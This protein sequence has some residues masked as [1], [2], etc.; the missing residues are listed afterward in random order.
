[1]ENKFAYIEK[2]KRYGFGM[3]VHFGIYSV[4]GQGEWALN[5]LNVDSQKYEKTAYKFN[6]V[7]DWAKKLVKQAKKTGCKYITLTTRHH[8]GFSLFDTKGLSD[9]DTMHTIG[10]DLVR[11]FVDACREQDIVPFFYHTLIDWHNKDYP[12]N[13]NRYLEYLRKSVEVLCSQYGEIGGFWFDGSWDNKD[14]DW[15]FDELYKMIRSYQPQTMIVNNTGMSARG[16]ISHE[17]IDSVT[18]ERG[19]PFKVKGSDKPIAGEMCQTLNDHWGYTKLDMNYKSPVELISNLA[20]CRWHNCNFLMNVGLKGNGIIRDID[21]AVFNMV[22]E[23]I[24][25]N[26]NFIYNAVKADIT[27]EGAK[28]LTDGKVYYAVID[29][30]DMVANPNVQLAENEKKYFTVNAKVKDI[31]W[32][33][34]GKRLNKTA[35]GYYVD[36]FLYGRSQGVRV[37]K[38]TI[39]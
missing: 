22:G 21:N 3:F 26:K 23:W 36:T 2:F 12:T 5:I 1:M 38:F 11:E 33:D 39:E 30:V 19:N 7:K 16:E 25:I 32:L 29:K 8:D 37:A 13:F 24:K 35:K 34:N 4:I 31:R 27:A 10:R 6:P 17:E 15:K 14:A 9:Y 18:F 28:I 20:D